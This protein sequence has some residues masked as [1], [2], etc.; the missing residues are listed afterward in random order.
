M[1]APAKL[2]SVKV[3]IALMLF[4]VSTSV[5]SALAAT[6]RSKQRT[7]AKRSATTKAQ[8]RGTAKTAKARTVKKPAAKKP[9]AKPPEIHVQGHENVFR[10][11]DRNNSGFVSRE[12]WPGS[13]MAFEAV[14]KNADGRIS[15]DE[16][17]ARED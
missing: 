4:G 1:R 14:D 8:A 10:A 12:E 17:R 15:L 6:A 16:L 2:K 9:A 5:P 13:K 3:L 11:L 7:P